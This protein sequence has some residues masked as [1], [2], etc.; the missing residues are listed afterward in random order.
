MNTENCNIKWLV[1]FTKNNEYAVGI[2]EKTE[3]VAYLGNNPL[4]P[5]VIQNVIINTGKKMCEDGD[6]CLCTDCEYSTCDTRTEAMINNYKHNPDFVEKIKNNKE[7][8]EKNLEKIFTI[9]EMCV[10]ELKKENPDTFKE[11]GIVTYK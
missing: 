1:N 10:E 4:H 11:G 6:I 5:F 9:A 2:C 8:V 7:N 3:K